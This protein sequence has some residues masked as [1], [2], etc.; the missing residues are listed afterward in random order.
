MYMHKT[1]VHTFNSFY[2]SWLCF[3]YDRVK[4]VLAQ[5]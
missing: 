4:I 1:E 2:I 5:G 3:L